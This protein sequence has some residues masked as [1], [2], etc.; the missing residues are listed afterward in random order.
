MGRGDQLERGLVMRVAVAP[1]R[2]G[3]AHHRRVAHVLGDAHPGAF[4]FELDVLPQVRTEAHGG[5]MHFSRRDVRY[6]SR[7]EAIS[8][9]NTEGGVMMSYPRQTATDGADRPTQGRMASAISNAVVSLFAEY[10]GRGPTRART[11][12]GRDVVTVILEETLTKAERRLVD[13]GED[14][15]V[16]NTRRT[17]Q[18][19][20]RQDLVAEIER[21]TGRRVAAFLSDQ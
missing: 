4:G 7:S 3:H 6:S 10:L 8:E 14:V 16:I 19:A 20:M 18:R 12:F 9:A 15:V 17:F 21:L 13:E 1:A 2:V 11:V 5:L